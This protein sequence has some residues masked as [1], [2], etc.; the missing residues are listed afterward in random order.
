MIDLS[1]GPGSTHY[2][3][4]VLVS[5]LAENPH[6]FWWHTRFWPNF[7]SDHFRPCF[8]FGQK[9]NFLLVELYSE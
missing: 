3:R 6:Y 8:G 2:S 7:L 9:R 5:V 4:L 1:F